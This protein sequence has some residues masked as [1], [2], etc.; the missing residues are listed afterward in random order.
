MVIDFVQY[1]EAKK[2]ER[3]A[4][5]AEIEAE[6]ARREHLEAF[7]SDMLAELLAA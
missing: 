4:E 3:A 7:L 5:L 1:V 2:A 6:L